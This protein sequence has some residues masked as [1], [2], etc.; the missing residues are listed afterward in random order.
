MTVLIVLM[1][2]LSGRLLPVMSLLPIILLLLITSLSEILVSLA[3]T[4]PAPVSTVPLVLV[5]LLLLYL[6][7]SLPLSP[8]LSFMVLRLRL[9]ASVRSMPRHRLKM[10]NCEVA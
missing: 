2:S 10:P 9:F 3:P 1:F 6:H 7:P 4:S 8:L 5:L